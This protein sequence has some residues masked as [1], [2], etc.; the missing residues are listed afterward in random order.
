[1][2][3]ISLASDQSLRAFLSAPALKVVSKLMNRNFSA[4]I[5][6]GAVRDLLMKKTPKDVDIV[7]NAL[8][9]Q[10]QK[11]FRSAIIV[12]RRFPI[13]LL[14]LDKEKIEIATFRQASSLSSV[15]QKKSNTLQHMRKGYSNVSYGASLVDD[16]TN[17]DFTVNAM[18]YQPFDNKLFDP[19]SGIEDL[20][21]GVIRSVNN[22]NLSLQDDPIRILRSFR[23][24]ARLGFAL[25][26]E[27]SF[28][29]RTLF[30]FNFFAPLKSESIP[31]ND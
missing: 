12:G 10:I 9:H 30:F 5:V 7:T 26:P 6:G 15:D 24:A 20:K 13:V 19:Q 31:L 22:P 18:Y 14:E 4:L 28:L 29:S 2:Q 25:D 27:V 23:F 8:P 21:K 11:V 3:S 1:M 17:R 16:S